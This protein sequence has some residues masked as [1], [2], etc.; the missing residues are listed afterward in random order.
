M[1][2][3]V[4]FKKTYVT[5]CLHYLMLLIMATHSSQ[6][7]NKILKPRTKEKKGSWQRVFQVRLEATITPAGV[8]L[9]SRFSAAQ[10]FILNEGH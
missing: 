9:L 10:L 2:I 4:E 1:E 5:L 6:P 8:F 3:N 7:L